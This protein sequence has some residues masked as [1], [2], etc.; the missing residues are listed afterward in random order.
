M[1]NSKPKHR[2]LCIFETLYAQFTLRPVVMAPKLFK[3]Q[4]P[5]AFIDSY[6]IRYNDRLIASKE[7]DLSNH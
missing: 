4:M 7:S 2:I 5:Q 6:C 3:P 1:E